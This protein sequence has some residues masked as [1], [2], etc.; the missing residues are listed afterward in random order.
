MEHENN[1]IFD[2]YYLVKIFKDNKQDIT[3]LQIQKLMYFFEAYYMNINDC[4]KLYDCNFNAWMF[5]PVAIPLYKEYKNF[6]EYPIVLSDEKLK[7]GE[8][9]SADKKKIL[10]ELYDVFGKLDAS[11]LVELTHM[12]NSPW[13]NKWN[14]N[15]KKI[16][17]GEESYI[18]KDETKTWFKENFISEA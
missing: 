1:I 8:C 14:E 11:K 12:I 9:I 4:N 18:S 7:I 17:Y 15:N 16:V 13:Y 5:G 6:G 2:S 3:Q 10:K